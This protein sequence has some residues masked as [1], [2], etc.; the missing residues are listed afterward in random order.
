MTCPTKIRLRKATTTD[1]YA[2]LDLGQRT[3][4]AVLTKPIHKSLV[5][6]EHHSVVLLSSKLEIG[7]EEVAIQMSRS[8]AKRCQRPHSV[9]QRNAVLI[10]L[11]V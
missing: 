10:V 4:R 9:T 2:G 5:P 7:F 8:E 3:I 6:V 11:M 1:M